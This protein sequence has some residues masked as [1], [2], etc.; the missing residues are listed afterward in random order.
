MNQ[1]TEFSVL[2]YK[3]LVAR[4]LDA[5]YRF[6]DFTY[7][8]FDERVVIFRHDIDFST[9]AARDLANLE[10]ELGITS[11]YFFLIRSHFYNIYEP[12]T[13]SHIREIYSL[14]HKIGLHFD[15][16]LYINSFDCL[17]DAAAQ[18]CEILEKI[19][20]LSPTVISFHRPTKSLLGLDKKVGGRD[21]TYNKRFFTDFGYVSDS[22]G[23]WRFGPPD[24]HKA[25][26][27]GKGMQV[28]THPIW[29]TTEGQTASKKITNFIAESAEQILFNVKT[30]CN[31]DVNEDSDT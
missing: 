9:R 6:C 24:K 23:E 29:W 2:G 31:V 12:T 3:S 17:N 15:A 30:N 1:S 28:L 8:D 16:S 21:H 27:T 4:F 25:F 26:S 13:L 22:S 5:N 10:A 18:E 19:V 20:G 14:G 11:T 7:K